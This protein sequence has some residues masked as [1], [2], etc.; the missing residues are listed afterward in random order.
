MGK[1]ERYEP[2]TL[3]WVDLGTT[4]VDAAKSFY[5]ALFGWEPVDQP[6]G[7]GMTY[8]MLRLN[9]EDVGAVYP[10]SE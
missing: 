9:G 2:G 10:Q 1:R 6:V 8:T 3:S 7:E 4:D 5:G